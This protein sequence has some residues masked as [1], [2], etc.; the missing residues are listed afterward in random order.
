MLNECV[1]NFFDDCQKVFMVK[2]EDGEPN[3]KEFE[4]P[5]PKQEG[6]EEEDVKKKE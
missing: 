2:E 1:N 5:A 3:I 4:Y 6:E